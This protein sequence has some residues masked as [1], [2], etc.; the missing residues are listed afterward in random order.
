MRLKNRFMENGIYAKFE[1]NKGTILIKLFYD[2]T[3]GTVGNFVSLAEG[4]LGNNFRSKGESYYNGLTFHRVIPDFMI[5]GGC[6]EGTGMGSPGYNFPDEFHSELKH[7]DSGILSMANAGPA[8][9]GSQFFITHV[10]TPW[11]DGKHTVFGKVVEGQDVVNSIEQNDVIE[12]LEILRVG[13][14]AENWDAVQ[15][16]LDLNE[17]YEKL[18]AEE[19]KKNEEELEKLS[20][21][22][23]KTDSG[24]R[25]KILKAGNGTHPEIGKTVT[26][27]YIGKL[28]DDTVFD[29]SYQ[30][31]QPIQFPLGVGK[32]IKGWDEGIALLTVEAKATFIIPSH[33]A[34]GAV[35][36]GGIIPPNATLIF[37]VELVG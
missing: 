37:D 11:L 22:F 2:K 10:A 30:R 19:Q 5:Q 23:E 25:Y 24:L 4:N 32:V 21:G 12:N 26:V 16:F 27:H 29:S 9:N 18:L 6:P 28:L 8:T 20:A 13:T 3:P 1:T 34:Y 14:E 17:N 35:G 31:N 7:D 15:A 33:L 36:A